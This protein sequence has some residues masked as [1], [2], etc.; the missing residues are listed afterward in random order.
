MTGQAADVAMLAAAS[1]RSRIYLDLLERNELLPEVVLLL[2]DPET[3]T[4]EQKRREAEEASDDGPVL[5]EDPDLDPHRSV[6]DS[7]EAAGIPHETL[8]TLDPNDASV[9]EAVERLDQDLLVYSGPGG[10]ILGKDLLSAGPRFL[11]VHAGTLL[12]YRGSTTVY[13]FL[14]EAGRCGATAFLMEKA[15]DEGPVVAEDTYPRPKS[16]RHST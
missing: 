15:L 16:P 4:P 8:Q 1:S 11:H 10:V 5:P 13:Y 7:V 9:V 14:L 6:R 3:E 2:D 12:E